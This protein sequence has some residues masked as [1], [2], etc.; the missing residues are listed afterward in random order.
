MMTRRNVLVAFAL[1]RVA[2][3]S[4]PQTTGSSTAK[5]I[6][7]L[8]IASPADALGFERSFLAA[9]TK[10]G[11]AVGRNIAVSRAYEAENVRRL[12]E[13]ADD[14]V[15]SGLVVIVTAGSLTTITAARATTQSPSSSVRHCL[16]PSSKD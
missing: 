7:L 15:R 6:G 3:P 10:R 14:L 16:G 1:L 12:T 13:L 5:R 11:W 9:L 4:C 8:A 2:S